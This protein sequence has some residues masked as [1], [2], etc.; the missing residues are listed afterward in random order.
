[1]TSIPR[2]SRALLCAASLA[3]LLTPSVY[4][5]DDDASFTPPNDADR[6]AVVSNHILQL[7]GQKADDLKLEGEEAL[8]YGDLEKALVTLR[9]ALELAPS[10][11][12]SRL[13]YVEAL[14]KKLRSQKDRDPKLYNA[15]VKQWAYIFKKAEFPDQKV[16]AQKHL[17]TLTGSAPGKLVPITHYLSKVMIPEDGSRE[18]AVDKRNKT[19]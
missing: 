9:K 16:Q 13:L 1:M 12:D 2:N 18:V 14:E 5:Q 19:E 7:G 4:A 6:R 3:C 17:E 10:N 8:R 15:T 11:M